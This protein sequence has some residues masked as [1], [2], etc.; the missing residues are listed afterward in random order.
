MLWPGEILFFQKKKKFAKKWGR[1]A[2]INEHNVFTHL[3]KHPNCVVCQK[4]KTMKARC[5]RKTGESKP[6]SLPKPT[7]FGEYLSA[8]HAIFNA[9]FESRRHDTVALIAQD[10]FT[11]WL[12]AYPAK[13]KTADECEMAFKRFVGVGTNADHVWS[14]TSEEISLALK[15]L[16]WSHDT[17]TPNRSATN[18]LIERA[19]QRTNEGT[20]ACLIQSGLDDQWWDLAMVCYCFLRCVVDELVINSPLSLKDEEKPALVEAAD[21]PTATAYQQKFGDKFRG[22][23]IPFGAKITYKPS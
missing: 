5:S 13:R 18:G 16:K 12:Q 4:S 2:A 10:S 6:D 22:P 23:I 1:S 14:D 15:R 21:V 17:S 8:D 20:S 19:V 7:R 9:G 11:Y 3:P